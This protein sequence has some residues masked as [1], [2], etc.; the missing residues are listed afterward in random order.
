MAKIKL[1]KNEYKKQKDALKRYT[2]YLPTLELK[3]QQ[4]LAEIRRVHEEM[5]SKR[6]KLKALEKRMADWIAVFADKPDLRELLKV[7]GIITEKGNIA[8]IDIPLFKNVAFE[9]QDYD[10]VKTP[11]WVDAGLE[12]AKD[13]I[14]L[15]KELDILQ[16][17]EQLIQRE[18]R[19]TVQR[20]NLFE[21]VMIPRAVENIRVIRIFMGDQDTAA[22][23][24]GKI[25]KSKI[26]KKKLE[27]TA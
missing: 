12:V 6:T 9:E 8:G 3:K 10:L 18:L 11:L 2:R 4:L 17:Q 26:E 7:K 20:I 24:R 5:Q 27:Q 1:T 25:S 13:S 22:V 14:L 21:K 19:T 23:V 16:E 15:E